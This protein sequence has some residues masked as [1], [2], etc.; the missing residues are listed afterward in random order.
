MRAFLAVFRI[1][2]T[3]PLGSLPW[4]SRFAIAMGFVDIPSHRKAHRTPT[5]LLGGAAIFVG[6]ILCVLLI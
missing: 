6:A 5:P 4:V 1:A 3:I 2:L